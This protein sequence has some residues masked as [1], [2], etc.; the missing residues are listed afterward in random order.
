MPAMAD[1]SRGSCD[2]AP[3]ALPNSVGASEATR[4]LAER[5]SGDVAP[6]VE[7]TA[8]A[9]DRTAMRAAATDRAL[10]IV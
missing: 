7:T 8:T 9:N 1:L 3:A 4:C 6:A 10:K 2:G 5:P